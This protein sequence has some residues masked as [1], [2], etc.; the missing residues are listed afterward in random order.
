MSVEISGPPGIG[1]TSLL[2][3]LA[4]NSLSSDEEGTEKGEVL[5]VGG[6]LGFP[7]SVM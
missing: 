1:K 6:V 4:L 3:G 5:I 7:V 2:I